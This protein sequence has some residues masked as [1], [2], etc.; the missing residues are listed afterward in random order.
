LPNDSIGDA[1]ISFAEV[2]GADLTLTDCGAVSGTHIAASGSFT[3][4]GPT[5]LGNTTNDNVDIKGWVTSDVNIR[6]GVSNLHQTI[7]GTL[8]AVG[9]ATFTAAAVFNGNVTMGSDTND[10]VL[11]KFK[12]VDIT[13][14]TNLGVELQQYQLCYS[15]NALR[16]WP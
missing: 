16:V 1:E 7:N 2:T 8:A 10:V 6:G 13:A 12:L 14:T 5:T 11:I 3:N 4:L 15:N 9:P